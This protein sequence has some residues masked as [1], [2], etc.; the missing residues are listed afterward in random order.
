MPAENLVL[1][2]VYGYPSYTVTFTDESGHILQRVETIYQGTAIYAGP[3]PEKEG[4][5]FV[6]W[7][8]AI[9]DVTSDRTVAPIF[10]KL[11]TREEN[12]SS[13]E[14]QPPVSDT[15]IGCSSQIDFSIMSI[16]PL[17]AMVIVWKKRVR[18]EK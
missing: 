18:G 8:E 3:A 2:P 7:S 9:S 4:Y 17:A 13:S 1:Y 11:P 6:G 16:I 10:E 15:N 12:N 5:R 14:Q